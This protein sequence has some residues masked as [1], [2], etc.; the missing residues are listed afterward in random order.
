ML[1]RSLGADR[2]VQVPGF[3]S[4][5]AAKTS[6]KYWLRGRALSREGVV[7]S[8]SVVVT[9]LVS[10]HRVEFGTLRACRF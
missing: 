3:E 2:Q 10:R 9:G 7:S 4:L 5:G 8:H 6:K 1:R